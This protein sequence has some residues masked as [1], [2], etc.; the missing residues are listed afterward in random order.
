LADNSLALKKLILLALAWDFAMFRLSA[1]LTPISPPAGTQLQRG[2]TWLQLSPEAI[3]LILAIIIGGG[4]G[5]SIVLFHRLYEFIYAFS[6]TE[7]SGALSVWGYWTLA[8]LPVIGGLIVG[9][10]RWRWQEFGPGIALLIETTQGDTDSKNQ[11][12]PLRTIPKIFATAISLGTGA[13]LGPEGPSVEIGANIG[14]ALARILGVSQE[15]QWLL[16]GAGAAAGLAAGFN[17][18]IAGV[19]LAL[20]VVLGTTFSTSA[21]SVVLLSAVVSAL[22]SQIGLG[23]KP[24]FSLPAYE[25]RSPW[26]LPLYM[27]LGLLASLIS[28]AF[29]R[30][31]QWSKQSFRGEIPAT[32]WLAKIPIP[33]QP[34]FGGVCLGATALV[35]PQILGVGY[36]TIDAILRDSPFSIGLL[37]L[38]LIVKLLMTSLSM[39]S[40]FVGGGFAPAMY[41]GACL[42]AFYGKVVYLLLPGFAIAAPPAYAMVGMAAVL[43]G[44]ARAPLTAVLL[45]FEMTRDYR[46]VLP[47]MAAA[48]LSMWLVELLQPQAKTIGTPLQPLGV[49]VLPEPDQSLLQTL[50][51]ERA[52]GPQ[53][54]VLLSSMSLVSAGQILVQA[55]ARMAMLIDETQTVVGI[56]TLRQLQQAIGRPDRDSLTLG[57]LFRRS[58]VY[59]YQDEPVAEA[60]KR[61]T[62]RGL[63]QLPVIDR[64]K[65]GDGAISLGAILGLINRDSIEWAC[66]LALVQPSDP[67]L[68]RLEPIEP[69]I[70][71]PIDD[72]ILA[73]TT[74]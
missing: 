57:D 62:A 49:E 39:G 19:F 27:G 36:E 41:L 34:V 58:L 14:T 26:E 21:I 6:R 51:V 13:S 48:G 7:L 17:A 66:S 74:A 25:V 43:A 46:I 45:L 71:A 4:T 52:M 12:K 3:V 28:I 8:C 42:G 70:E 47:L 53:L 11:A 18:P 10:M 2:L 29:T 69:P 54:P 72:A 5:L 35:F 33:L 24:A 16:L 60:L 32:I 55:H 30:L 9:L 44:S 23:A 31:N 73:S 65:V 63:R 67:L 22:V 37:G 50:E 38:L 20:E 15:R 64:R 61:M 59:A 56:V 1:P 68:P 40:G